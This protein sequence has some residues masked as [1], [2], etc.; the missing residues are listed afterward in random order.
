MQHLRHLLVR[1]AKLT[2]T[3]SSVFPFPCIRGYHF[4]KLASA[5]VSVYKDIVEAGKKGDTVYLDIGC[6]S[7]LIAS[8]ALN[9][10][11]AYS[12]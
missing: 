7:K 10:R 11:S 12:S 2:E 3:H 9:R 4:I 5:K 6:C 8:I 1:H